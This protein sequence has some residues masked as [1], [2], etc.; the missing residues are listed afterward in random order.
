MV[1][2]YIPP[3]RRRSIEATREELAT[4]RELRARGL[5]GESLERALVASGIAPE[6]ARLLVAVGGPPSAAGVARVLGTVLTVMA[7]GLFLALVERPL[8]AWL[9]EHYPGSEG[10]VGFA[11]P[12]LVLLVVFWNLLQRRRAAADAPQGA[13]RAD[14]ID[15][16]PIG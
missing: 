8:R 2:V 7:L 11:F 14:Q 16:R 13:T 5:D 9:R 12:L 3:G 15:N 1:F 6:R 10:L 4:M